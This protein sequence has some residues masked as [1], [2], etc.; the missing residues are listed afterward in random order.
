MYI[1]PKRLLLPIKKSSLFAE[2]EHIIDELIEFVDELPILA[3]EFMN[4]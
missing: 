4:I 2:I 3:Y 1:S